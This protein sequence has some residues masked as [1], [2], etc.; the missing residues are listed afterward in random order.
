MP[1]ARKGGTATAEGETET[2]AS[3][4]DDMEVEEKLTVPLRGRGFDADVLR[5]RQ[6]L[7]KMLDEGTARSFKNV[8]D[9][10][11]EFYARKV[12]SAGGINPEIKVATRYDKLN[13]K[14]I[15]GPEAVLNKLAG[16]SDSSEGT[17]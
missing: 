7:E 8:T 4:F 16:K 12:R 11:R 9:E 5:I 3:I 17:S 2:E 13:K 1:A 15:W 6:E 14:L 10:Q